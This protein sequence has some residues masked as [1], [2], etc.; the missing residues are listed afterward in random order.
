M[1]NIGVS[2]A[3]YRAVTVVRSLS[4]AAL[5]NPPDLML[6]CGRTYS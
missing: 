3:S 6:E 5:K 4:M 2:R 1:A